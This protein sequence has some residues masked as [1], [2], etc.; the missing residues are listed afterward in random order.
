MN[1]VYLSVNKFGVPIILESAPSVDDFTEE[2]TVL[3]INPTRKVEQLQL[4]DGSWMEV[5]EES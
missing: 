3:R 1:F 5:E 2:D 4:F